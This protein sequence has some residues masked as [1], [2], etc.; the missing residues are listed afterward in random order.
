M[1]V[2]GIVMTVCL[3]RMDWRREAQRARG[4]AHSGDADADG[5]LQREPVY[6][7][8]MRSSSNAS[9]TAV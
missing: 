2:Q 3:S 5:E 9:S 4:R 7:L 1:N 8:A 6:E